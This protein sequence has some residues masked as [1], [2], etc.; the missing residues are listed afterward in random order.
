MT[1]D[2]ASRHRPQSFANRWSAAHG[3]LLVTAA[4]ARPQLDQ[5]T[6]GRAGTGHVEA[7]PR[8]RDGA[9]GVH[10]PLLAR[11]GA[12]LGD[13]LRPGAGT[14]IERGEAQLAA[15]AVDG[16]LTGTGRRPQLVGPA[17]ALPDLQLR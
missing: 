3:P 5:R 14:T 15:G 2:G 6:V 12:R 13:H 4:V 17:V 10:R 8:L 7:H 1:G 11:T 16:Q 9:V